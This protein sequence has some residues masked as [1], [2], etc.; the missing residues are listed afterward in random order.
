VNRPRC[1]ALAADDDVIDLQERHRAHCGE[2]HSNLDSM[3][4]LIE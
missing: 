4:A 2:G 1:A 3:F